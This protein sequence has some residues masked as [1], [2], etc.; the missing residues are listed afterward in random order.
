MLENINARLFFSTEPSPDSL[1]YTV[2]KGE[3]LWTIQRKAHSSVELI[4]LVNR[5]TNDVL[6][7]GEVLKIPQGTFSALVDRAHFR[8]M[9]FLN[10]HYI[11]EYPVGIGKQ[12]LTPTGTFD[13]EKMDV[14]PSWTD[15]QGK[16]HPFGSP[17]N[18]LGSR[19]IGFKAVGTRSGLGIHG[20]TDDASIGTKCSNGCI[21]MHNK[22]VEEIF[23]MLR[24][25]D[26][27]TVK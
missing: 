22:D 9:V 5:K 12:D 18:I 17:E 7:E 21:R 2:G 20:T 15:P 6:R 25:G 14:N 24:K 8:L 3:V 13:V 1:I 19:W 4:K 26:K 23:G 11:K 10:G 16:F 27:V